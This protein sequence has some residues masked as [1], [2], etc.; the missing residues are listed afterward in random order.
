[1]FHEDIN[2]FPVS[3]TNITGCVLS[4]CDCLIF[5]NYSDEYLIVQFLT[6]SN[7]EDYLFDF[8]TVPYTIQHLYNYTSNIG[9]KL[10][11]KN[12]EYVL[13]GPHIRKKNINNKLI[14][15]YTNSPFLNSE[16]RFNKNDITDIY[17]PILDTYLNDMIDVQELDIEKVSI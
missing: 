14:M 8:H 2:A 3:L 13:I 17:N 9:S 7:T 1:M 5:E 15:N 4:L 12:T 6:G 11:Q 10:E 16:Y